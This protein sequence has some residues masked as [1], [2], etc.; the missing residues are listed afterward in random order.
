MVKSADAPQ[1]STDAVIFRDFGTG[2]FIADLCQLQSDV[3]AKSRGKNQKEFACNGCEQVNLSSIAGATCANNL[4]SN[5]ATHH[6]M[7]VA[8]NAGGILRC[9]SNES[10]APIPVAPPTRVDL[11]ARAK[12]AAVEGARLNGSR[13][14]YAGTFQE[15]EVN[16]TLSDSASNRVARSELFI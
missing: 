9:A 7:G 15:G 11:G 3:K 12:A 13:R 5:G 14:T 10:R 6:Y 1:F 16:K 2:V 4:V 8:I